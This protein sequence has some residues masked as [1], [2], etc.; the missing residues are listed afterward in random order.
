MRRPADR[1]WRTVTIRL[2]MRLRASGEA[3]SL[4]T[5]S[6]TASLRYT[7]NVD[8]IADLEHVYEN[9][10]ALFDLIIFP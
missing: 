5:A 2:A 4:D 1:A 8:M 6:E 3:V 10:L 7:D 9:A